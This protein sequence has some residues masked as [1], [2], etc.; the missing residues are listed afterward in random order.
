MA[1]LESF[2]SDLRGWLGAN[3]PASLR[4]AQSSELGTGAHGALESLHRVRP[5]QQAVEAISDARAEEGTAA[6][7]SAVP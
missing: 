6:Q 3:A 1:E 2:R 7:A 5:A 4:G